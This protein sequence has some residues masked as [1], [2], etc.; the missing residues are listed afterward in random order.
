MD[1]KADKERHAKKENSHGYGDKQVCPM[2]DRAT[3]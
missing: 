3:I 1:Y 2:E